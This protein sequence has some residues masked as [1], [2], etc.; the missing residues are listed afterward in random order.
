[1]SQDLSIRSSYEDPPG[2]SKLRSII[3][4][5]KNPEEGNSVVSAEKCKLVLNQVDQLHKLGEQLHGFT[6]KCLQLSMNRVLSPALQ[7]D[8]I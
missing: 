4:K 7:F 8:F 3:Q 1:M 5:T 2:N 6:S